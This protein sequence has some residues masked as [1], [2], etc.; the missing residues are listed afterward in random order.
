[1]QAA[2]TATLGGIQIDPTANQ[3]HPFGG[4]RTDS[5]TA[6]PPGIPD[7]SGFTSGAS[8]PVGPSTCLSPRI[9]IT[10]VT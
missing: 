5:L 3:N 2:G 10:D 6:L 7:Q 9:V 8:H 1:M 4:A